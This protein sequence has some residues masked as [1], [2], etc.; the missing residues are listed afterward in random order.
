MEH[1]LCTNIRVIDICI[2]FNIFKVK[3]PIFF[4]RYTGFFGTQGWTLTLYILLFIQNNHLVL[5]ARQARRTWL[6]AAYLTLASPPAHPSSPSSS[7]SPSPHTPFTRGLHNLTS[8]HQPLA[9]W[10]S[11]EP[12]CGSYPGSTVEN[13]N[14]WRA[15]SEGARTVP[16]DQNGLPVTRIAQHSTF[17]IFNWNWKLVFQCMLYSVVTILHLLNPFP[18]PLFPV[19]LPLKLHIIKHPLYSVLSPLSSKP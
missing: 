3:V 9:A 18:L 14:S 7:S 16:G 12:L 15:G 4:F 2:E 5:R 1:D 8:A 19:H 17:P 10:N 11:W 13:V 6:I